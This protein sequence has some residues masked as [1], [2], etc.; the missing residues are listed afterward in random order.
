MPKLS[1]SDAHRILEAGLTAARLAG[2]IHRLHYR[3]ADLAVEKKSDGTPVTLSDRGAEAAIREHLRRATPELGLLGEEF[4]AEG[5]SRDR[6]I[7][8]PLDGTKNFV[9]GLPYF[10]VLI[11]LE[12]D[13]ELQA[14]V[15]HA[16][17]LGTGDPELPLSFGEEEMGESWWAVRGHGAFAGPGTRLGGTERS[18]PRPLGVSATSALR[19]AFV[20]HG[21][22]RRIQEHGS[23]DRFSSLV[24]K[25][26]RTRGFGDWWG[27]M[28]V[29]E[30]R[31][32]AMFE[33]AVA[34]HDVAAVKVIVEEAGGAFRTF[35]NAPLTTDFGEAV[36]SS[37]AALVEELV[38]VL[39]F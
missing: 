30:G 5:D 17:V 20:T 6:W 38:G 31:C 28:L 9:S 37:N 7:I 8:D 21:G 14:G 29:A 19:Q 27:H 32:D 24:A 2:A 15:I 12:L 4:G 22:L 10:A 35:G 16:P 34:L 3:R 13:G 18:H 11:G 1:S 39:G 36:L 33:A 26:S 25:V 23:W